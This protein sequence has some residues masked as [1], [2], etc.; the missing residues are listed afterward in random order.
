M[1]LFFLFRARL[2]MPDQW[3]HMCVSL[4]VHS[5]SQGKGCEHWKYIYFYVCEFLSRNMRTRVNLLKRNDYGLFLNLINFVWLFLYIRIIAFNIII[6]NRKKK[7]L[8][9][10]SFLGISQSKKTS[11]KNRGGAHIPCSI[12]FQYIE[13][14]RRECFHF[15]YIYTCGLS[16]NWILNIGTYLY[17]I[18]V[19]IQVYC[20]IIQKK[21]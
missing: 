15:M 7:Q 16:C 3:S 9:Y 14:Y 1:L 11:Y 2:H 19:H 4:A 5:L 6:L 20:L 12:F 10:D 13:F 21:T 17:T 18:L 8:R